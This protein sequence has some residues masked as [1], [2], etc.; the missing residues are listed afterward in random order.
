MTYLR[1]FIASK[2]QL[3][4]LTGTVC[5]HITAMIM[6]RQLVP[7][8]L[9]Q[10]R[11]PPGI[12][13]L[14]TA[15]FSFLPLLIALPGGMITDNIGYRLVMTS[16]AACMAGAGLVLASL[17][18]VSLVTVTQLVAG[19]GHILLILS[20]QAY[21]ANSSPPE[22]RA[23]NFAI[24]FSGPPIGF[25]VGP[26]LA[27]ILKDTVGFSAAFL[28]GALISVAVACLCQVLRDKKSDGGERPRLATV[29]RRQMPETLLESSRLLK[30]RMIQVSMLMGVSVLFVLTLRASFLLIHLEN[31]GYSAFHIG[32]IIAMISAVSLVLRPFM[33]VIVD[34][35]GSEPV[36][37]AAF[38][39]GAGGLAI[40]SV[41]ES[42]PLLMIGGALFGVAPAFALPIS[43]ML[44][45]TNS[46]EETQ[47]M[48]MGL[49]QTANPVGLV[50]G[51]LVFGA[52]AT[53][54]G[55]RLCLVVAA[56]MFFV[57]G[58][59]LLLLRPIS[60]R[61]GV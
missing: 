14:I 16:G 39:T 38:L 22:E 55:V 36:L 18:T 28:V 19:L 58:V 4:I 59:M 7:L 33:G 13:G 9:E 50:A 40:I 3:L 26:P 44:V 46:P 56:G 41:G 21:V 17:P 27:G 60:R 12:I 61:G 57:M 52:I 20:C 53:Y 32:L 48:V 37:S 24:F 5:L 45:S 2:K 47:G 49:R 54:G 1:S 23:R 31:L 25:L 43:L 51:P 29:L 34:R 11:T 15:L 30:Q 42:V 35:V 6:M 8:Y 10:L